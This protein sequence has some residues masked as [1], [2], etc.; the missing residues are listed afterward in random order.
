MAGLKVITVQNPFDRRNRDVTVID[1]HGQTIAELVASHLPADL[2]VTVSL[3]GEIILPNRQAS[4][5]PRPSDT[6]LIVPTVHGG[7]TGKA[8]LRV[9]ITIVFTVIGA[10]AGQAW[11]GPVLGAK[12]GMVVGGMIGS[13][14][15]GMIANALLPQAPPKIAG[16]E[17][18]QISNSYSWNPV[19][20]QQQGLVIPRVYGKVKLHG[21]IVSAFLENSANA[22]GGPASYVNCLL[23]IGYGPYRSLGEYTINDQPLYGSADVPGLKG[24]D[25]HSRLGYLDQEVIPNFKDTKTEHSLSVK[26]TTANPY[27]YQ[28]PGNDF[29]ELEVEVA[30]PQGLYYANDQGGL[31]PVEVLFKIEIRPQGASDWIPITHQQRE[32]VHI[33]T[34]ERWSCG[35]WVYGGYWVTKKWVEK[36][37]GSQDRS[38]HYD[39]QYGGVVR[40]I[41]GYITHHLTWRWIGVYGEHVS[42]LPQDDFLA[43]GDKTSA[44][45]LVFNS[46]RLETLGVYEIRVSRLTPEWNDTRHGES[47]YLSGVREVVYDDFTYP[48]M[49]LVGIRSLATD[50]LSG[51]FSFSCMVEGALIRVFD[52]TT[53]DVQYSTNPA[54]V[55]FDVLTQ[56]VFNDDLTLSRYDGIDP[57]RLDVPTF[58]EWAQFCDVLVPDGKGGQEPRVTFNGSFDAE[59]TLW[60]AALQV[61]RI[62]RATLLWNGITIAVAIDRAASPVQ[63]F[64][65]GNIESDGFKVGYLS[66]AERSSE[67]EAD[68]INAE[69]GYER[70][71]LSVLDPTLQNRS[72][73]ATTNLFGLTRPSEVWRHLQYQLNCNKY[74][75]KT[76]QFQAD[77]DAIVCTIGDVVNVQHDVPHWGDA[78]GR[79]VAADA[80]SV[81]LDRAVMIEAGKTYGIMVKLNANDHL[82]T[83]VITNSPGETTTLTVDS[84]FAEIPA[85][86]DVYAFGESTRVV[87]PFKV[88]LIE[89]TSEQRA[90]ITGIEYNAS[91]YG[92]DLGDPVIPTQNYSAEPAFRSVMGLT[93][94]ERIEP[95]PD[96]TVAD[97]IFAYWFRPMSSRIKEFEVW[98]DYGTGYEF[99]RQT[100][101]TNITF[102]ARQTGN[103]SIIVR[104]VNFDELKQPLDEAASEAITV[105]GRQTKIPDVTGLEIDGQGMNTVFVGPDVRL[106]WN[107]IAPFLSD[108]VDTMSP[109]DWFR[110]YEVRVLKNGAVRRIDYVTEESYLYKHDMNHADGI[111]RSLKFEVRAIAKWQD[112]VSKSPAVLE[113][114]NPAPTKIAAIDLKGAVNSLSITFNPVA[115]ID[116]SGYLIYASRTPGFAADESALVN[117]GPETSKVLT[118]IVPGPWYVRAA[119]YDL[120]G[121]DQI[122]LSDEYSAVVSSNTVTP[123]MLDASQRVDFF[124]R[125]AVL[126][127]DKADLMW[128]AGYI[129]RVDTV[130][131]LAAGQIVD[132]DASYIV[133]TFVAATST[134]TLSASSVA[135]G[136]PALA[137]NQAIIAVTSTAPTDSGNYVC[138]VRQGNAM[139][140][141]AAMIRNLDAI[142]INA[143]TLNGVNISQLLE[144][145]NTPPANKPTNTFLLEWKWGSTLR[146]PTVT[147]GGVTATAKT[148]VWSQ[149]G[150]NDSQGAGGNYAYLKFTAAAGQSVVITFNGPVAKLQHYSTLTDNLNTTLRPGS[151][152]AATGDLDGD[153]CVSNLEIAVASQSAAGS[154]TLV[155][156]DLA[157]LDIGPVVNGVSVPDGVVSLLDTILLMSLR[158]A[159]LVT[160]TLQQT[161]ITITATGGYDT[162]VITYE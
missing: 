46:G 91:I 141:D 88:I 160:D 52:G 24:I 23:G 73:K 125:D 72:S 87:K 74:L 104:T 129:D 113:V 11:L 89:P 139:M 63:L 10:L 30:F 156:D 150:Y 26:I 71:R 5:V 54:W 131:S 97:L 22:Q 60:D 115:D 32:D 146:T 147:V 59:M 44:I 50:Q 66:L 76:V 35:Y 98:A 101:D 140:I 144:L 61:A 158:E 116:V 17:T 7:D 105:H 2:P 78:G 29:D 135:G 48:R 41:A 28:T 128:D 112:G 45:R 126:Y 14:V 132:A 162:L 119:A 68:F 81:T 16:M 65:V 19:T 8:I 120:F 161:S 159:G 75:T 20:T 102:A 51:S 84:P 151:P 39:G 13:T 36:I 64:T 133:A 85:Q 114:S 53:W 143:Q 56:P 69:K 49:A 43:V 82:V 117:R 127:F 40:N 155:G 118:G 110:Y 21:N 58:L 142:N 86:Y 137:A 153:G 108:A 122:N 138:Y 149:D 55:C 83:R 130:Y 47:L 3:N 31:S 111:S 136:M 157:A 152:A 77:I 95:R 134:V 67:I 154:I 70:D 124:V 33:D 25:I 121:E 100:V 93:V 57:S 42:T 15:G 96:G 107:R 12:L 94:Q 106:R 90:T 18:A 148:P 38:A 99:V 6:I 109:H 103:L 79:L 9:V 123:D 80:N 145:L 62:G 34:Y 27:V 37:A 1:F 4:L 92:S